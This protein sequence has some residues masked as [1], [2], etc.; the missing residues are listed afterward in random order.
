MPSQ[1]DMAKMKSEFLHAHQLKHGFSLRN[2]LSRIYPL[3]IILEASGLQQQTFLRI[4]L[5][6]R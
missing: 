3:S 4:C 1:V 6:A 2:R 5:E